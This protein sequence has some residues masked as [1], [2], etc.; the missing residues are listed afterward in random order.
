MNIG[1]KE[2]EKQMRIN[3]GIRTQQTPQGSRK[4]KSRNIIEDI[5]VQHGKCV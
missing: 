1:K 5:P 2:W 3:K 4:A